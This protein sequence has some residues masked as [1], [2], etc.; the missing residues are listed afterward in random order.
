[1]QA[2]S[3]GDLQHPQLCPEGVLAL[4]GVSCPSQR[5]LVLLC[6]MMPS[7]RGKMQRGH[8]CA[9]LRAPGSRVMPQ[10]LQVMLVVLLH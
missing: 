5:G 4:E 2:R 10:V 1:M 8:P 6:A 9:E 3:S 7:R